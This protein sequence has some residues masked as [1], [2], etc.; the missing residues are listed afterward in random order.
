MTLTKRE[1]VLL[2]I[3]VCLAFFSLI[4][5]VF[6]LPEMEQKVK[7]TAQEEEIKAD[8]DRKNEL[9]GDE[10]LEMRYEEALLKAQENYDYF[11]SVLNSYTIDEI[12]NSLIKEHGLQVSVLSIGDYEEADSDFEELDDTQLKVLVKS[13]ANVSV[14]GSYEQILKFIGAMNEKSPCLKVDTVSIVP[15]TESVVPGY[16]TGTF[17]IYVYGINSKTEGLDIVL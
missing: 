13:T 5:V 7:L 4:L 11:Y 14:S 10:T 17:R 1:K 12:L 15:N 16:M 9:L 6:F 2:Q 3:V 8:Y